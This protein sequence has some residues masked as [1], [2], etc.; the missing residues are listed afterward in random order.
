MQNETKHSAAALLGMA[1]HRP[2]TGPMNV[3]P[4]EHGSKTAAQ[5]QVMRTSNPAQ[6]NH[7]PRAEAVRTAEAKMSRRK[8]LKKQRET[9]K[10]SGD[11]MHPDEER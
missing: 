8:S 4:V 11:Q 9:Q 5:A 3:Q 2:P 7:S 6:K 1:Q 10:V